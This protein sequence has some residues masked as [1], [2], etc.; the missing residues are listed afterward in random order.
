M[1]PAYRIETLTNKHRR[2]D[3]SCGV[4][5]L[6]RYFREQVSQDIRRR[7][8]PDRDP[9]FDVYYRQVSRAY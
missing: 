7:Y 1:T 9:P 3:F 2:D 4:D 5:P 6:D 8:H